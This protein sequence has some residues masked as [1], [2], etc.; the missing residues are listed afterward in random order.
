MYAR[1]VCSIEPPGV[2][3]CWPGVAGGAARVTRS[4]RSN[5]PSHHS[6]S[7]PGVRSARQM[8]TV[9]RPRLVS[10][11]RSSSAWRP[12]SR[13][14]PTR[15]IEGGSR[16]SEGWCSSPDP[17]DVLVRPHRDGV[18]GFQETLHTRLPFEGL[19][20]WNADIVEPESFGVSFHQIASSRCNDP[21]RRAGFGFC[22]PAPCDHLRKETEDVR[23]EA[24]CRYGRPC[25]RVPYVVELE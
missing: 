2:G 23:P 11:R 13:P 24:P 14:G 25:R 1:G 18:D 4:S 5:G 8:R 15:R 6:R 22:S 16:R 9:T 3:R 20:R 12:P 10:S 17:L 7:R 19:R 21:Y